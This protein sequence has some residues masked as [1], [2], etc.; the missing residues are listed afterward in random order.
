[1]VDVK[2]IKNIE[3]APFTLMSSSIAIILGFILALL[4]FIGFT[5]LGLIWVGLAFII[6]YP[7]SYFFIS[8]T[9]SF[10]G[11]FLYN[12]LVSRV[13]GI[14]LGMEGDEIKEVP[15]IPFALILAI[16]Q[17]IWALI[18]GLFLAALLSAF[19]SVI[20]GLIPVVSQTIANATN[21]TGTALPT[22]ALVAMTGILGAFVFIIVIP[23]MVLII[24]FIG[25]ALAAIFYNYI[26]TRVAKIKLEFDLIS[27]TLNE[28]KSI[29]VLP[30]ALAAAVV[31]TIFGL[32]SGIISLV[33][34]SAMGNPSYGVFRLI[35]DII[36]NFLITLIITAIVSF[37]YNYLAPR[38]G[39]I[40]LNLE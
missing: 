19:T 9:I 40:K 15:V 27:G 6:I 2:E 23:I 34:F 24:G 7:L 25:N 22:G 10:F 39:G 4:M 33:T 21:M 36:S 17:A 8:I 32:I 12:C 16:I 38:I 14:K 26:A 35:Y 11:A 30:L 20:S 28:L 1:M 13:G 37:L 5:A 18:L 3:L 29:P 31:A